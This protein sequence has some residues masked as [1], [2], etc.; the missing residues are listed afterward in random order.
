MRAPESSPQISESQHRFQERG[1]LNLK[2]MQKGAAVTLAN[3]RLLYSGKPNPRFK[4]IMAVNNAGLLR[5]R[6]SL[7][8]SEALTAQFT[9]AQQ[10]IFQRLIDTSKMMYQDKLG[11]RGQH[12]NGENFWEVSDPQVKQKPYI[13][14]IEDV[15]GRKVEAQYKEYFTFVPISSS[16]VELLQ[17]MAKF[18]D[19]LF[20]AF[21][22]I[23]NIAREKGVS[24][25]M[26]FKDNLT[27]LL[28]DLDSVVVY[29]P[30][31]Q[32]GQLVRIIINEEM[33]KQKIKLGDRAG[34]SESGFDLRINGE[35]FSHR[36]LVGMAVAAV[37]EQDYETNKVLAGYTN[38]QFASS[39][40]QRSEQAS[41]LNSEQILQVI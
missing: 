19:A 18:Y 9:P 3:L 5:C 4:K 27:E 10:K 37:M 22:R 31:S 28:L 40:L 13:Q 21:E 6:M 7:E 15:K 39:L 1:G 8:E 34:R 11:L 38:E 17:D 12:G 35:E 33:A 29:V 2:A 32:T 25:P 30:D 36:Q 41:K 26:K 20:R 23:Q 14:D 24:I 16:P